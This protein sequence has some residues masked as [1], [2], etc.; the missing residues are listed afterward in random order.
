MSA[1]VE[2]HSSALVAQVH[3]SEAV[4]RGAGRTGT[5]VAPTSVGAGGHSVT[6]VTSQCTLVNVQICINLLLNGVQLL[7]DYLV[8]ISQK[9][10]LVAGGQVQI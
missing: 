4:A 7:Y 5:Q 8:P 3:A 6:L 1:T 2:W 9:S 10:P